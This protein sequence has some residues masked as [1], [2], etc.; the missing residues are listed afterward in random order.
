MKER[1]TQVLVVVVLALGAPA[2]T[3][4]VAGE[5]DPG[6]A[7][8]SSDDPIGEDPDYGDPGGN[9]NV[10]ETE[11]Q[12]LRLDPVP[13]TVQLLIDMSGSMAGR[14][15]PVTRW[16]A[17]R[18]AFTDASAGV[19]TQLGPRVHFGATLYNS[20]NG[21]AGGGCAL[22]TNVPP[23]LDNAGAIRDLIDGGSPAADTPTAEAVDAISAALVPAAVGSRRFI[24]LATDG[25]PDTCVDPDAHTLESKVLAE[26]AVDR[27]W[28]RGVTT[29]VLSV[30][31]DITREHLRRTANLG[32]GEPVYT[33]DAPYYLA[34]NPGELISEL[35][36]LL[37][38]TLPTCSYTFLQ[39]LDMADAP[40]A[41]ITLAGDDLAY[42]TDWRWVDTH[43]IELIGPACDRALEDPTLEVRGRFYCDE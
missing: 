31:N 5:L 36:A 42:G 3:A 35:D 19:V 14:F 2:C 15:G 25:D 9:P 24:V 41:E 40:A 38:E 22:M 18:H 7:D 11:F 33:G 6:T 8:P 23:A 43:T 37:A 21:N 29:L 28:A 32:A 12:N 26:N 16:Q 17:V 13:P 4:T 27:A 10:C 30:G 34:H 1:I 39:I 20:L